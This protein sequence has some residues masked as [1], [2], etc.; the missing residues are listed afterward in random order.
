ME[1][2]TG[3]GQHLVRHQLPPVRRQ[4]PSEPSSTP[5]GTRRVE[6]PFRVSKQRGK[7]KAKRL[8]NTS[9]ATETANI[10][11]RSLSE[12]DVLFLLANQLRE[13][14]KA[15]S[16]ALAAQR[17][18]SLEIDALTKAYNDSYSNW[19]TT[20]KLC[21][22]QEL[23]L[24][25][26]HLA[27][28][29]WKQKFSGYEKFMAGFKKDFD[30]QAKDSHKLKLEIESAKFAEK[31]VKTELTDLVVTTVKELESS[32]ANL[33]KATKDAHH[34][35]QSLNE[36]EN[37]LVE[38]S[39]LLAAERVKTARLEGIIDEK[40]HTYESQVQIFQTSQ[41]SLVEK[42]VEITNLVRECK[43]SVSDGRE[44]TLSQLKRCKMLI[45]ALCEEEAVCPADVEEVKESIR[46]LVERYES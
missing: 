8:M 34:L 24:G 10:A 42:L 17:Q 22:E 31:A 30:A 38:T 1:E 23:E 9:Q 39:H 41:T 33:A 2:S 13:R 6:E 37:A 29:F 45:E 20:Q 14:K 11:E 7:L 32:A 40:T 35:T 36:S 28:K 26:Y 46:S 27:H 4:Q 15:E 5:L 19:E 44:A 43:E 16:A 21:E 12:D 25:R 18:M 3:T